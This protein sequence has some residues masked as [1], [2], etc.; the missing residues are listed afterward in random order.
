[1]AGY[2][3][4]DGY[5][6]P[7]GLRPL[8]GETRLLCEASHLALR[9]TARGEPDGDDQP[10][11]LI[12]G[13]MAGD[14]SLL[15]MARWLR[16]RG[17]RTYRAQIRSNVGC[18][19]SVGDRL[20]LRLEDIVRRRGRPVAL[21][22]HSLGGLLAKGL[23]TRRP[24]LVAGVVA[25]GSPLLAPGA[26]HAV[27]TFDLAVL[28]T[29]ERLG[30]GALV[31][32]ADCIGGDC[33][34]SSWEELGRALAPELPFTSVYSR[35]DG[36][37]DWRACLDPAARHVEVVTSHLGMAVDAAVW[38]AVATALTDGADEAVTGLAG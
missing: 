12:P 31:M 25:L 37:V 13:F 4:P 1:M 3:R 33:A 38:A 30:L 5:V 15:P 19:R 18:A 16:A 9:R 23:A 24:D 21:V 2:L 22:G 35:S 32:G 27:L 6:G 26:V 29:L 20:E 7:R 36:I 28:A 34:R 8:I 10:V 11:L 14:L 17:Y